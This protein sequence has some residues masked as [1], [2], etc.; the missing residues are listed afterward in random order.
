MDT[1]GQIIDRRD[2]LRAATC[3]AD[4]LAIFVRDPACL[5]LA[6]VEDARPVGVLQREPFMVR[7]E[8]P[9]AAQRPL[10]DLMDYDL[11]IGETDESAAAFVERVLP[12]RPTAMAGGFVVT[13]KGQYAGVCHAAALM[14]AMVADNPAPL[15][16]WICAELREPVSHALAGAEGLARLRLP[17]AAAALVETV[18]ETS[19]QVLGLLDLAGDIQRAESGRLEPNLE[20]R[21]LQPL[22]DEV[23]SRWSGR[24]EDAGVTLL[25]SYDGDPDC[26]AQIDAPR[27]MQVFDALIGH[28]LAHV[29][30]GVIEASLKAAPDAA[31]I[32]VTGRVRDNGGRYSG[33]D[34][35]RLFDGEG[36]G[37]NPGLKLGMR[38]ARRTIAAMAGRLSVEPNVGAGATLMFEFTARASSG[39]DVDAAV[40][41]AYAPGRS[42]HILVVDDNATNRM[43]VE[44]LCEMFDCS[45]ESVVDG[46]EAVEAARSGRFDVVLMDIKMPRM[47]GV[48]ATCEIRKLPGHAG[49]VPIIALTANADP[50][51]VTEY[52]AAGMHCVV[53]KPVKPERLMEALDSALAALPEQA[54]RNDAAAA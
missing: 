47:D 48:V 8:D 6:V 52:L 20:S 37:D 41:Q 51:E 50:D 35:E 17:D 29:R 38:L 44:A 54:G 27:L 15:A 19:R 49:Q 28:A 4:A 1:L 31:G 12:E 34:L 53:E 33:R 7:M 42:A 25:V 11:L 30:H 3:C 14:S 9:K 26:S 36:A 13:E 22:M 40:D 24:A 43:V 39:D 16:D 45:T 5:V 21:P 23:S 18:V 46:I 10:R 2:A 32:A